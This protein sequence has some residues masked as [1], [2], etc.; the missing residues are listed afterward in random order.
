MRLAIIVGHDTRRRGAVSVFEHSEFE[1]NSELAFQIEKIGTLRGH[2][3]RVFRHDPGKGYRATVTPTFRNVNRWGPAAT[4]EL[5]FN[6]VPERNDRGER[7]RTWS[8]CFGLH[9]PGSGRGE[10]LG[11]ALSRGVSEAIGIPDHGSFPREKSWAGSPLLG[12]SLPNCPS[13]LLETHNGRNIEDVT[14]FHNGL[15]LGSLAG[16][17]VRAAAEEIGGWKDDT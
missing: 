8:G 14:S 16:Y 7:F 15:A 6:S 3:I 10:A 11:R 5:H 1:V 9:F 4:I 13:V 12:L 17:I 2:T